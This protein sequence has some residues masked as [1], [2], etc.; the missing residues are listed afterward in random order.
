MGIVNFNVCVKYILGPL[1]QR[2]HGI[3]NKTIVS[4]P[5]RAS[6]MIYNAPDAKETNILEES[7]SDNKR[8][9][10]DTNN[11]NHPRSDYFVS[12]PR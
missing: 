5:K 12:Q 1:S 11:T 10:V 9:Q 7:T 2:P 3:I 6:L 8:K 4:A